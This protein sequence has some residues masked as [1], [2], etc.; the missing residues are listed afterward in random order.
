VWN[1]LAQEPEPLLVPGLPSAASRE[2]P[3]ALGLHWKREPVLL[4][5]FLLVVQEPEL[6]LQQVRELQELP[7]L[8]AE[9]EPQVRGQELQG[10][11]EPLNP[12]AEL[13][14]KRGPE[15]EQE[16]RVFQPEPPGRELVPESQTNWPELPEQALGP[17]ELFQQV[18]ALEPVL[19]LSA[20]EPPEQELPRVWLQVWTIL[21][22]VSQEPGLAL[23]ELQQEPEP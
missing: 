14:Q 13:E 16:R 23:R 7:T 15:L 19:V 1:R 8:Q 21:P 5:V 9:L 10:L 4:R 22:E 3:L 2:L 12:S 17:L 6:A 11:Q 20:L 18:R